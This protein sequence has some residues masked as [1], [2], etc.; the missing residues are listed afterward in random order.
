MPV[1]K[2]L[3][4]IQSLIVVLACLTSLASGTIAP[5]CTRCVYL[6]PDN[7]V[8]VARS[9]DWAEDPGSEVWCLPRGMA[10]SGATGPG[11]LTWRST[12]GSVIVSFYGIATVDGI[13]EKGLVANTLYLCL[14][15]TSPSP[16]D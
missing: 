11:T 8:I 4:A 13:N 9:M 6:G 15:Y 10:R 14:L 3:H 1:R 2:S 12:Y 16:R 5:A 7:S